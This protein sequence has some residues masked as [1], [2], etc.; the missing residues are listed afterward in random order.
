MSSSGETL[1]ANPLSLRERTANATA[2][3][4]RAELAPVIRALE[5]N[6]EVLQSC[7]RQTSQA[8][9]MQQQPWRR[10]SSMLWGMVVGALLFAFLQPRVKH[11]NNACT[12][13]SEI[14]TQWSTLSASERAMIE[15]I[16]E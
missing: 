15:K 7:V 13:G 12:L 14:L 4:I 11:S 9:D 3:H 1:G 8:L 6:Q 10:A 2:V 5:E 16:V